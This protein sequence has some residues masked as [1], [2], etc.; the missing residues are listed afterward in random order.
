MSDYLKNN[1]ETI[2]TAC[3]HGGLDLK[4]HLTD[5]LKSLGFGILDLGTNTGDSVD[6]PDFAY[7][8]ADAI[9]SGAINRGIL[10]CGS[11]IG[12]SMAANRFS[13]VRAALIHDALSAKMCRLHNDA[14]IICFGGRMIGQDTAVDCLNIFLNTD[15]EGGRHARR[16]DKLTVS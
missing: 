5:H 4:N 2:A 8:M 15:F 13:D 14:N 11:G 10:V 9:K 12:I 7:K 16:V 3:D 6:Y 1:P